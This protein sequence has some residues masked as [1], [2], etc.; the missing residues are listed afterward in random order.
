MGLDADLAE[1]AA[2]AGEGPR[3]GAVRGEGHRLADGALE[4]D[5]RVVAHGDDPHLEERRHPRHSLEV[6]D[7]DLVS[8][9]DVASAR[10]IPCQRTSEASFVV[11][12]ASCT[13]GSLSSPTTYAGC[14]PGR[15]VA[16]I[17]SEAI[18]FGPRA[19]RGCW[20]TLRQNTLSAV[21]RNPTDEARPPEAD[22]FK[23]TTPGLSLA[24]L[25]EQPH[26]QSV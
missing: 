13:M 16:G 4:V 7:I 1:V 20:P 18:R 24:R 11:P 6:A 10:E 8:G 2:H 15:M 14:L 21:T 3:L 17:P 9:G 23:A 26:Q 5:I 25:G 19:A 12:T 22:F